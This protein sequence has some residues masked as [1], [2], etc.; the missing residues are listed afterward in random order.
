MD[1][2]VDQVRRF[3]RFYTRHLGVLEERLLATPYSLTEA[4]TLFEVAR[5]GPVTAADLRTR[6]GID[7]GY[8]SR[9]IGGLERRGILARTRSDKDARR[10]PITLTPEGRASFELLDRAANDQV[11]AMVED[12]G[13]ARE[14]ALTDCLSTIEELLGQERRA[15]PAVTLREP[16]PGEYGWVVCRHGSLYSEE[17]GWDARFEALVARIIADFMDGHDPDAERAWIAD[18]DGEPVGSVFCVRDS[19][20]VA[21]LR[22]L[23]VDPRA[24]GAGIGERLVGECIRFAR[25]AGYRELVLWTNSVLEA[26][27][28]IYERAGFELIAEDASE[29]FGKELIGQDWSL[30]L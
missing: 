25:S 3:N 21:R 24:R 8:M 2:A 30:V 18:L 6:L 14:R 12:L 11:A 19:D 5:S 23:L 20:E 22:L 4:R 26:A 27:R 29:R 7:A 10:R 16:R 28:R 13:P 1:S 9:V 17:Y 15:A